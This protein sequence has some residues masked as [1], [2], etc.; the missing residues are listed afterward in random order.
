MNGFWWLLLAVVVWILFETIY[1]QL[2]KMPRIF[3]CRGVGKSDELEYLGEDGKVVVGYMTAK[4]FNFYSPH[5]NKIL[6]EMNFINV[7]EWRFKRL[8]LPKANISQRAVTKA[9]RKEKEVDAS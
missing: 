5:K 4:S 9:V 1:F 3:I 2:T 7:D 6:Q 8:Q